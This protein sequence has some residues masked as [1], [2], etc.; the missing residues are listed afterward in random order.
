MVMGTQAGRTKAPGELPGPGPL[1]TRGRPG[2]E[3]PTGFELCQSGIEAAMTQEVSG[4]AP[5]VFIDEETG[6]YLLR[7]W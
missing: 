7:G 6:D 3:M 1:G 5:S 2:R 4:T